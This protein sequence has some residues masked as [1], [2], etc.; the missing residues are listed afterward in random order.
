MRSE[1]ETERL[2]LRVMRPEQ[3]DQ[4]LTFYQVNRKF[5]EPYEPA[6][7]PRFYTLGF[8]RANLSCEYN[9]FIRSHYLRIW[10]FTKEKTDGPVGTVCFSN[11]LYGAF[12]SCM[13]GYKTG[14]GY[15]RRGYMMESLIFLLPLVC[16]EYRFHRIEAYVM[17]DNE[18]SIRLL[19]RLTFVREGL[20]HHFAKIN[21][22]WEDHF[23]YSY[24]APQ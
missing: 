20:L 14:Q 5:L 15:L 6:R 11:F 23:L 22:R 16:R 12:C 8:Q 17:P 4:I 18:P 9:A 2:I 24:L 19:E 10:I 13:V 7:S 1:Y 21:G 3:A